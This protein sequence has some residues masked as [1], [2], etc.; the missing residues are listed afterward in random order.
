LRDREHLATGSTDR[1]AAWTD[2]VE[3]IK[4]QRKAP[5]LGMVARSFSERGIGSIIDRSSQDRGFGLFSF[6]H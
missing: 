3:S 4:P 6:I 2:R 5:F 1:I